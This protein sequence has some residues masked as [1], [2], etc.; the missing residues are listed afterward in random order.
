MLSKHVTATSSGD[1]LTT[2]DGSGPVYYLLSRLCQL[3]S[4]ARQNKAVI[5]VAR[6]QMDDVPGRWPVLKKAR[7]PR[8]PADCPDRRP[9]L[10]EVE[11]Q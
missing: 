5:G 6:R 1:V 3:L 10:L 8:A 7:S 4:W 2:F 9:P 11:R